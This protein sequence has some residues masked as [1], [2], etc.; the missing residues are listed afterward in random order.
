MTI[1][2]IM[3]RARELMEKQAAGDTTEIDATPA[4]EESMDATT[5]RL[6]EL[7]ES[8]DGLAQ[9]AKKDLGKYFP[10]DNPIYAMRKQSLIDK[11]AS[12]LKK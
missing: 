12:V 7:F 6:S 10:I 5:K 2:E 4:T 3:Q 9:N 1:A 8:K 11:V